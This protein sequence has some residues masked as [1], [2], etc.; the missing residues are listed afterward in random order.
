[1]P[2]A[3]WNEHLAYRLAGW[4]RFAAAVRSHDAV[5]VL[6]NA[7]L[8]TSVFATLR[9]WRPGCPECTNGSRERG[10]PRPMALQNRVTPFGDLIATETRG[11]LMGN[12]GI[13][14]DGE[15]RIVRYAVGPRWIACETSFSAARACPS[16]RSSPRARTAQTRTPSRATA[17]WSR[18]TRS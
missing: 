15:R 9:R 14:H 11:L 16:T 17:A 3:S 13:L 6:D 4:S 7:F 8:Q 18:A 10:G 2:T 5:V 1:M 12:R